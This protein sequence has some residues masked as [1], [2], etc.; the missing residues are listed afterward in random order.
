MQS[1]QWCRR[2]ITDTVAGAAVQ[3]S[4]GLCSCCWSCVDCETVQAA[5]LYCKTLEGFWWDP[6]GHTKVSVWKIPLGPSQVW[7]TACY[8]ALQFITVAPVVLL[9]QLDTNI[10]HTLFGIY[11]GM[12][13]YPCATVAGHLGV[14]CL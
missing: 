7:H 14:K 2:L 8:G 6:V 10:P 11:M 12:L 9:N 13:L 1:E 4:L 5:S 3:Q